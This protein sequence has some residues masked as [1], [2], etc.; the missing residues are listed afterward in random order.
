MLIRVR[1]RLYATNE[2]TH[3]ISDDLSTTKHQLSV[4]ICQ[5]LRTYMRTI[6][7]HN[8]RQEKPKERREREK[9]LQIFYFSIFII[10][11]IT[12][13]AT[14]YWDEIC[15]HKVVAY[16]FPFPYMPYTYMHVKYIKII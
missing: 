8:V 13:C 2:L 6:I 11:F 5:V 3:L 7:A 12:L 16:C 10:V 14:H 1:L 4:I 15:A 9:A